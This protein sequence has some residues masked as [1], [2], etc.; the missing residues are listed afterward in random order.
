[1]T[2]LESWAIPCQG[3]QQN[4]LEDCDY[5]KDGWNTLLIRSSVHTKKDTVCTEC[6][7]HATLKVT[8]E[9]ELNTPTWC[10]QVE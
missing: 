1:M 10:I 8:I 2:E 4:K 7:P 3:A 9:L 6:Y 5:V